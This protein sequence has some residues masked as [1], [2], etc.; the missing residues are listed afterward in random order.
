MIDKTNSPCEHSW[1]PGT[2]K[3]AN[4]EG[5]YPMICRKCGAYKLMDGVAPTEVEPTE[6]Y[7]IEAKFSQGGRDDQG[8][9]NGAVS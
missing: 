7:Q 3:V 4:A 1:C 9:N 5:K 2:F 8:S 6:F